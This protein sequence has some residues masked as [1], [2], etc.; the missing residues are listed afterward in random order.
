MKKEFCLW[1]SYYIDLTPEDAVIELEKYGVQYS[2]LSDEHGAMLLKRGSDEVAIGKEFKAFA[3]KHHVIFPQGHLWLEIKIVTGGDVI[4]E[5]KRWINLFTA[6]GI[7][8]MV[9]HIDGCRGMN[10]T[11]KEVLDKN[12]EVL[13]GLKPFLKDKDVTICLENV[14]G[15]PSSC[16][17]NLLYIIDKLD[18]EHFGITLDTGHLNINKEGE[19]RSQKDFIL[20]AGK[21]LQ[22]LH[23]ADNEGGVYN[24][25]HLMPFGKGNV[26]FEEVF[27]NLDIIGYSGAYNYEI[28]GERKAPL[29]IRGA[30]IEYLKKCF[31]YMKQ[32]Y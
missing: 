4:P 31:N 22:A 11:N 14:Y 27:K 23:I 32:N 30:K 19:P 17:E 2:E 10:L 24:D 20:K 5:L 12:I 21:Y 3:D 28:P 13:A 15:N 25:Q 8:K 6:V 26:D 1:S 18:D 7:K 16:V 29:E 9:L